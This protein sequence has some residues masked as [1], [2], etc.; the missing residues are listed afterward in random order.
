[1]TYH[2]YSNY[3]LNG[4]SMTHMKE[5]EQLIG[6]YIQDEY[7]IKPPSNTL[8]LSIKN[9]NKRVYDAIKKEIGGVDKASIPID[10]LPVI[11]FIKT[12]LSSHHQQH[13][14]YFAQLFKLIRKYE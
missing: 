1:M 14:L 13:F 11:Q 10:S 12:N 5:I 6:V 4:L 2:V 8:T 3:T 9:I 7:D